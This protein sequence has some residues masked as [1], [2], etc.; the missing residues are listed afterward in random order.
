MGDKSEQ[1]LI[2]VEKKGVIAKFTLN[3][4]TKLNAIS[5]EMGEQLRQAFLDVSEDEDTRCVV[6]T[7]SGDAFCSG[8]NL[9]SGSLT[10]RSGKLD[11]G[12][13]LENT[14]HPL[15]RLIV[16]L[17]KPVVT[18]VKG[19]VVGIGVS[20]AVMGDIVLA[21]ESAYFLTPFTKIGLVPDG[22]ATWLLPRKIGMTRA[23]EM[24][25]LAKKVPA[26]TAL[27]WG[28][29][30]RVFSDAEYED[31]SEEVIQDLASMPTQALSNTRKLIWQSLEN[32]HETQLDMERTY[33]KF[34][35]STEDFKEGVAAFRE[36]RKPEF[37]GK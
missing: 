34:Q 3:D 12:Q 6:L 26:K 30:N 31:K 17:N 14:Y 9:S 2:L 4:P 24:T 19:P 7:G 27:E 1:P 20:L 29:V 25:M 18:M 32:S 8:A 37:K 28:L 16:K 5:Q 13:S 11:A 35:G 10:S 33:Q 15:V 36:K 21:H 23:M 22:G